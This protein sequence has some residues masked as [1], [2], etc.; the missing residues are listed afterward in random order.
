MTDSSKYTGIHKA[1]FD[2][3]GHGR[4]IAGR[5]LAGK[6]DSIKLCHLCV[7]GLAALNVLLLR[8]YNSAIGHAVAGCP[9]LHNL[10]SRC[11]LSSACNDLSACVG[12]VLIL[13]VAC[14][15]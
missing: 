8:Y 12:Y 4:G 13:Y 3:D 10:L 2:E 5:D 14:R 11:C 9:L 15:A 6:G 7:I 1:R